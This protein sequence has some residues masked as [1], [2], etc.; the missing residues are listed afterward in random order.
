MVF[1][2]LTGLKNNLNLG[3]LRHYLLPKLNK[4]SSF[5]TAT[6]SS[7]QKDSKGSSG[8]DFGTD[9]P[10]TPHAEGVQPSAHS[11]KPKKKQTEFLRE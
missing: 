6:N 7:E 3:G 10:S 9:K 11:T 1:K 4:D 8:Q 2:K 5:P